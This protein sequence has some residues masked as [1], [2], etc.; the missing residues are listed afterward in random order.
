VLEMVSNGRDGLSSQ[1]KE[2]LSVATT[3]HCAL[4]DD[5]KSQKEVDVTMRSCASKRDDRHS[6]E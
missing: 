2:V 5:L 6:A 4:R 1:R 3:M